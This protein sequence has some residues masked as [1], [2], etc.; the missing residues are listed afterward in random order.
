MKHINP[1]ECGVYEGGIFRL[2]ILSS[3]NKRKPSSQRFF[4]RHKPAGEAT[5]VVNASFEVK[6][7]EEHHKEEH[8]E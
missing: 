7:I 1:G 8:V 6:N 4:L 2:I 3:A 5:F